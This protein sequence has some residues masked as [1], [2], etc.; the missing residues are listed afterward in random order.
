M[1]EPMTNG[2]EVDTGLQEM[3]GGAMAQDMGMNPLKS[4]SRGRGLG[5]FGVFAQE[6]SD[7]EAGERLTALIPEDP[8]RGVR[9]ETQLVDK[10]PQ[11]VASLGPQGTEA[12]L[13]ALPYEAN[14]EGSIQL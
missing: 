6:V 10:S 11:L 4:E 8:L 13:A 9:I 12:F 7:S 2:D 5:K 14:L 1:S 3:D